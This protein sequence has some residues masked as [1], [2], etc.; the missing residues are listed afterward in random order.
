MRGPVIHSCGR[1]PKLCIRVRNSIS[2]LTKLYQQEEAFISRVNILT[3][4]II[5]LHTTI[6]L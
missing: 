4:K 1:N 3:K 5:E 6:I 2:I